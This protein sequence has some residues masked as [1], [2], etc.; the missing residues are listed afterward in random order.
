MRYSMYENSK[1]PIE[2]NTVGNDLYLTSLQSWSDAL[3]EL[4]IDCHDSTVW[5]H[6]H[7]LTE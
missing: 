1:G 7:G 2:G 3:S 4:A 6:S 5:G